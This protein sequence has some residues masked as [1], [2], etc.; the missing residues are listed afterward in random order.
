MKRI[1]IGGG[2][3]DKGGKKPAPGA[4]APEKT[5]KV[6]KEK[7]PREKKQPKQK[8]QKAPSG[9]GQDA[10][11]KKVV[12][13]VVLI[14]ALGAAGASMYLNSRSSAPP[15]MPV[16]RAQRPAVGGPETQS[17]RRIQQPSEDILSE[18]ARMDAEQP[19]AEPIKTTGPARRGG[20]GIVV[21]PPAQAKKITPE[22]SAP[23][24]AAQDRS[25]V[26][27]PTIPKIED[28]PNL[29]ERT[30]EKP[31]P[32]VQE[33]K[34]AVAKKPSAK[35]AAEPAKVASASTSNARQPRISA[36]LDA[37]PVPAATTQPKPA[38]RQQPSAAPAKR[39]AQA[40][41]APA[42]APKAAAKPVSSPAPAKP[43]VKPVAAKVQSSPAK[44]TTRPATVQIARVPS[45]SSADSSLFD[46]PGGQSAGSSKSLFDPAP[47][48]AGTEQKKA[49]DDLAASKTF[50]SV[51]IRESSDVE[52][53]RALGRRINLGTVSPEIKQTVSHGRN[54][55]WLTVGHYTTSGKAHN[56]AEELKSLGFQ[57]TVISEKSYY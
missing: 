7:P 38:R 37:K 15:P 25:A 39:A 42:P 23:V 31:A 41:T 12:L 49:L 5:A 17:P 22:T 8:A 6:K 20:G 45:A 34:P 55:Y 26:R 13:L 44:R 4:A 10:G 2:K 46:W 3:P 52:E 47:R 57:A 18:G 30:A 11:K 33:H 40:A 36:A 16:A 29:P 43:A 56:K 27:Q 54:V 35:P 50:Y 28:L 51:L 9:G 53:L 24:Q 1:N 21:E 19:A 14:I 48:V 32:P